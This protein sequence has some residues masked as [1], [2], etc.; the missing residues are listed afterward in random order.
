MIVDGMRLVFLNSCLALFVACA[1]DEPDAVWKLGPPTPAHAAAAQ[2][3]A[4]SSMPALAQAALRD[5]ELPVLLPTE[6][7]LLASVVVTRGSGWYG[8]AMRQGDVGVYVH[9]SNVVAP[10]PKMAPQPE[11]EV[12]IERSEAMVAA[13]LRRFGAAYRIEVS[14][15]APAQDARCNRDDYVLALVSGL[16]LAGAPQ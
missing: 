8:A 6:P 9:G 11:A 13:S 15:A 7:A 1:P 5:I 4:V 2:P 10:V 3:V 16:G 14:C 12:R